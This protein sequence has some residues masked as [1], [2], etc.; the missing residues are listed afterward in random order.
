[1]PPSIFSLCNYNLKNEQG[2]NCSLA[3]NRLAE[4][5]FLL[6]ENC[7]S[8]LLLR[9]QI[10]YEK[11]HGHHASRTRQKCSSLPMHALSSQ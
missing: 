7:N 5:I 2:R 4:H 6:E 3:R 10:F 11:L 8:H 9:T 1:M